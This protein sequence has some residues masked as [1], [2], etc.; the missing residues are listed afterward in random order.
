MQFA[1]RVRK[2]SFTIISENS[3]LTIFITYR[4][5][6]PFRVWNTGLGF[7]YKFTQIS[8]LYIFQDMLHVIV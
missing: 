7:Q 2:A 8:I 3:P 6:Y 5:R 4:A 1:D